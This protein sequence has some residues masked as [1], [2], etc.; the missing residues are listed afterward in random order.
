MAKVLLLTTA[1][2]DDPA[3]PYARQDF[4]RL[5]A[6]ARADRFGVHQLVEDP[7]AADVILFVS[8]F[9]PDAGDVLRHPL[10]REHRQKTFVFDNRDRPLPI[11]PGVYVCSEK[12][13][14]PRA[15][16][17]TGGYLRVFENERIPTEPLPAE[18]P[19]FSFV[20][21][22]TR[23]RVRREIASLRHPRGLIIDTS[24]GRPEQDRYAEALRTS[25]FVLAPR[26]LGSSSWRLFETMKAGRAP[27]I[28]ADAW[29][30]PKG[31]RWSQFSVRVRESDVHKV[32]EILEK[33]EPR[34]AEMG[35]L[36][37][38]AWEE[39]FALDTSF[40]RIVEWCLDIA[41]SSRGRVAAARA[42]AFAN[43]LRPYFLRHVGLAKVRRALTSADAR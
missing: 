12:R 14:F 25:R 37:R 40:H 11:I 9:E 42:A 20:G 43:L 38:A 29:R 13:W 5:M 2:A 4:R 41:E 22:T 6:A 24:K 36:A 18:G 23:V 28:L 21:D 10:A 39:W 32:P 16:S 31:P 1:P 35:R 26:G 17:R 19:L 33:M 3:H 7:D 34:A 27:V 8:P 30:P 15:V